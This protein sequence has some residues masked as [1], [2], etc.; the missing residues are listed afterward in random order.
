MKDI[1]LFQ[2]NKLKI[3]FAWYDLWIG[4][5]VDTNKK[6]LYFCPLPMLLFTINYG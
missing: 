2:N 3:S 5:F 6:K 1:T 4:L